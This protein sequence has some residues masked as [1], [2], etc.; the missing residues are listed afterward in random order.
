MWI[1]N[2]DDYVTNT[3]FLDDIPAKPNASDIITIW[4]I[5]RNGLVNDGY[6]YITLMLDVPKLD[7]HPVRQHRY[8]SIYCP[9]T[10][11]GSTVY[12]SVSE[13]LYTNGDAI[14]Q[15]ISCEHPHDINARYCV[16]IVHPID[17]EGRWKYIKIGAIVKV[18]GQLFTIRNV[19]ENRSGHSGKIT[20]LADHIFY[21]LADGWIYPGKKFGGNNGST[22]I[23]DMMI[24]VTYEHREGSHVYP[25]DY[26]SD[27]IF[28]NNLLIVYV[29]SGSTP[30]ELLIGSGGLIE[31]RGGELYRD[32]FYFS[33]NSR[34]ENSDD[35]AFDIRIGKNLKGIKRTVDMTSMCSYFRGYDPWGGWWAFAWDFGFFGDMFSHYI[36]RSQNFQFPAESSEDDWSY[37]EWFNTVFKDQVLAYFSK[38]GKPVIS[39]EFDIEDLR[40][41][42]DFE[43]I[44]DENLRVGDKGVIYDEFFGNQPLTVEITGTVYDGIR[45]KCLKIIV[46]DRQSFVSTSMPAVDFGTQPEPQGGIVPIRDGN[47]NFMIDGSG[48][49]IVQEVNSNV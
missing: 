32:N 2:G 13:L 31:N 35:H 21:Q 33:I 18:M 34:M 16:S 44:G 41:N 4:K 8:I 45:E 43:I 15:P 29:D 47:G 23:D 11:G 48:K 37:D 12:P 46:G 39:Y 26:A 30:V 17:P 24:R 1:D 3:Q 20:F 5:D 49:R 19:Q 14:L 38:N 27:L 40:N 36:V 7:V 42:P 28:D 6:P 9:R 22:Y 10:E 25:F